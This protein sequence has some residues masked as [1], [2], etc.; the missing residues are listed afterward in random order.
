MHQGVDDIYKDSIIK[1]EGILLAKYHFNEDN[2]QSHSGIFEGTLTTLWYIDSIGQL[3]YDDMDMVSDFYCN[4]QFVG[5][6]KDYKSNLTKICNWGDYRVPY[7]GDLDTGAGD[8]CI[9]P[10]YTKNGW[11][12]YVKAFNSGKENEAIL[13]ARRI[14]E[15]EWWK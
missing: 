15:M 14:E 6:W 3:K 10:K 12:N 1:K 9:N 2:L 7:S 5:T 8:F 4:N 13:Q 11:E